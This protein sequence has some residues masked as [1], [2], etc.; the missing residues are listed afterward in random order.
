M[1][2]WQRFTQKKVALGGWGCCAKAVEQDLLAVYPVNDICDRTNKLEPYA[3]HKKSSFSNV[4][5][6]ELFGAT[7]MQPARNKSYPI[8]ECMRAILYIHTLIKSIRRVSLSA[9]LQSWLTFR[10]KQFCELRSRWIISMECRYAYKSYRTITVPES[11]YK[12]AQ[13]ALWTFMI[14]LPM[15]RLLLSKH[16]DP[17]TFEKYLNLVMMVLIG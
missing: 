9:L 10:T 4:P 6:T 11:L 8:Y 14:T 13:M 17:K 16:K 15:L 12:Q 5:F 1:T 3:W 2:K 7:H